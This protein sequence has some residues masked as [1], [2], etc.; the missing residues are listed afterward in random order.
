MKTCS[1]IENEVKV[2]S[3]AECD[4]S[5][6][7]RLIEDLVGHEL[8]LLGE[9][10]RSG[11]YYDEE[12]I[13]AETGCSLRAQRRRKGGHRY[14]FKYGVDGVGRGVLSRSEV[15][16]DSDEPLDPADPFHRATRLLR[17]A[18]RVAARRPVAGGLRLSAEAIVTVKRREY[19]AHDR[20]AQL[21]YVMHV[22]A[23]QVTAAR[24]DGPSCR[25]TE[26]EVELIRPHFPGFERLVEIARALAECGRPPAVTSKYAHALERL[27]RA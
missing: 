1:R 16:L 18:E 13:F 15:V 26:L 11:T 22:V 3:D 2:R 25:F 21:G 6:E 8:Q 19:A 14:V 7:L 24:P 9:S 27:E 20:R 10:R 4:W 23:D 5:R 17:E 12:R